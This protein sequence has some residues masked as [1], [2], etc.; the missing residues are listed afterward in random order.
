M[1][2]SGPMRRLSEGGGLELRSPRGWLHEM[3]LPNDVTVS[4]KNAY[5][6]VQRNQWF[7]VF[8]EGNNCDTPLEINTHQP[9]TESDL[10]S[11]CAHNLGI[12]GTHTI[13]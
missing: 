9:S 3:N 2:A 11:A 4:E 7:S 12:G 1:S 6:V 5:S 13:E 10:A 8:L